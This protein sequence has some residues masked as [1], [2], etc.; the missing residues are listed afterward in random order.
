M[1]R[2]IMTSI[3]FLRQPSSPATADDIPTAN[4]LADTLNP[5]R[6]GCVGMAANM[7]GVS[8]QIIA[9]V[10]ADLGGRITVMLNPSIVARD[11][12]YQ[13]SEG[14]LSL[15]GERRTTR[16]ERVELVWQDLRLR[17]R[18]GSFSGFTAQ[19]IQH[20]VDHC[21]GIII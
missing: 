8:K 16:Y 20:E 19:I 2:A 10:D 3:P 5:H 18:H 6:D 11:G 12:E 9:F 4:D 7:I 13:T 1:Q 14:C 15:Q 21:E 17:E